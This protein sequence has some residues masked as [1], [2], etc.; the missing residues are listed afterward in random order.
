MDYPIYQISS[1]G[2]GTAE[3]KRYPLIHLP[4]NFPL[5]FLTAVSGNKKE[6]MLSKKEKPSL[7]CFCLRAAL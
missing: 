2:P 4:F 1:I 5:V 3:G 7:V 6:A